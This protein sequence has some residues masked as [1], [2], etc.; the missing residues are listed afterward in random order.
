M[1]LYGS[2]ADAVI[3][4]DDATKTSDEVDLGKDYEWVQIVIPAI[5]S[6]NVS[7]AVAEKTGGTFQTL[8]S[9]SAVITAGL[10]SFTTVANIGGFQFIKVVVSATQTTAAVTFRVRGSRR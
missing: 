7:F 1:S 2:W 8:G 3:D 5:D 4:K 9:G 10:G 6:A